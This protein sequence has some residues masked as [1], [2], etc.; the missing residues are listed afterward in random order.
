MKEFNRK[1]GMFVAQPS[2]KNKIYKYFAR[3]LHKKIV[4]NDQQPG[5]RGGS[6][7]EVIYI[8]KS[9]REGER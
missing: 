1:L 6:R 4:R 7:D 2:E 3:K 8:G 9:V 5:E